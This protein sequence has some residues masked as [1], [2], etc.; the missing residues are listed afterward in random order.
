MTDN[1]VLMASGYP[2]TGS[3]T[4][5]KLI[6]AMVWDGST[7]SVAGPGATISGSGGC[8]SSTGKNSRWWRMWQWRVT[9]STTD[10]ARLTRTCWPPMWLTPGARCTSTRPVTASLGQG[11]SA[12]IPG[13]HA[14]LHFSP[15]VVQLN[16]NNSNN[17]DN[18]VYLGSD[19]LDSRPE[20][21]G[22]SFPASMLVVAKLTSIAAPRPRWTRPL[23]TAD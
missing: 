21:R 20:Y 7:P 12:D 13:L 14:A 22:S 3:S 17:D 18:T 5:T 2:F 1:R 10:R 11:R 19:Q 9:I 8:D 6:D 4:T 23:A 16:R 15:A